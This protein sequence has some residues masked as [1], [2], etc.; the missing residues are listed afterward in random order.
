MDFLELANKRFSVR[1]YKETPV[2][3]ADIEK[4]IQAARLAP[5]A[6][7]SQPWKFIVID[8]PELKKEVAKS[9]FNG[10]VP[11]NKFA[12]DAP[13]L[14]IITA[15]KQ[16]LTAKIG[17]IIK[18]KDFR[19]FDI[20]IAAE[21]F[22]LQAAELGLGTCML[23]WFNEKNLKKLLS[24]PANRSIELIIS[25]G[26]SQSDS[27]PSKNRKDLNQILTYNSYQS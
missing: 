6:C 25:M 2:T 22:C 4:C 21:H 3:K 16:N 1:N 27:V 8:E 9:A 20:G 10:P 5:S 12:F 23:G 19:L 14:I 15:E 24:L 17:N 11:I 13:V 7:N 18:K 26:Y